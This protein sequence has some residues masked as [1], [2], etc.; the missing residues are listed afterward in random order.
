MGKIKNFRVW[1][2]FIFF[3]KGKKPQQGGIQRLPP[4]IEIGQR[5]THLLGSVLSDTPIGYM[6]DD[7]L[8]ERVREATLL[9]ALHAACCVCAQVYHLDK[10]KDYQ[11]QKNMP[12]SNLILNHSYYLFKDQIS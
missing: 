3:V 10:E 7:R 9:A 4:P 1:V 2:A 5:I 12:D 11:V 8:I 6:V